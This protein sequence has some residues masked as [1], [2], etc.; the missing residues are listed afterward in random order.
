MAS[1]ITLKSMPQDVYKLAIKRQ[2]KELNEKNRRIN[3]S[4]AII[5]LLKEA[6]LKEKK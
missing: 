5:I 4:L 3:L 6:Y 2:Q 1:S